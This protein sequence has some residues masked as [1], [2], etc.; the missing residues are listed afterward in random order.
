MSWPSGVLMVTGVETGSAGGAS[1]EATATPPIAAVEARA[2]D[3][4]ATMPRLVRLGWR[5]CELPWCEG[6]CQR[7]DW[8][9][10]PIIGCYRRVRSARD[11]TVLSSPGRHAREG[12]GW[13]SVRLDRPGERGEGDEEHERGERTQAPGQQHD[14]DRDGREGERAD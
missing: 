4:T 2:S 12:T 7:P 14:P 1:V 11:L 13:L 5:M 8:A 3:A 9:H 6:R 10:L